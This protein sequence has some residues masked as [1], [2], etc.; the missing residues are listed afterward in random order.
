MYT[1]IFLMDYQPLSIRQVLDKITEGQIRIPAFQREFVW[2]M[3]RVAYLMDSIYKGFPFGS[4]LFWQTRTKLQIER[5]L[6][7]FELPAP[8]ADY[9]IFYVLDGQQ[10]ITSVFAVFQSEL[11]ANPGYEW[12]EIYFDL[13]ANESA[14]ETQFFALAPEDVIAE[15]HFPLKSL[16]RSVDYRKATALFEDPK[17]IERIDDLQQRFKEATIPVQVLNTE[18]RTQVAI[19]FERVNRLGVKLDTLQLLAAWTW[20]EDFDLLNRFKE[21][22]DELSEFGFA[23]V[24]ED[25]DLIL[26]CCA[27]VLNGDPSPETLIDLSGQKVRDEFEK[28][29]NGIK[30]AI[31]F[32]RKQ[33][34]VH[35]LKNLPYPALLLPLSVFFAE[36]AGKSVSYSYETLA[37][38]K[39]WFWRSCFSER[40]SSQTMKTAKA[41]I[42]EMRKLKDGQS[43]SLGNR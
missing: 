18:D 10:R 8:Q 25:S 33:T 22:G 20:N 36:P 28:V 37:R 27:A 38:I 19:V 4:L 2:E 7:P 39:R 15:R 14:Q 42:V 26:R 30:G 17:T 3:D 5:Q 41:D 12:L 23:G 31:D 16:F 1:K 40:Y 24:G 43:S 21:L 32:L 11:E 35:F 9:P 34:Q 6:G 29:E 13:K